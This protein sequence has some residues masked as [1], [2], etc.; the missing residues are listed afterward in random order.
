MIRCKQFKYIV[1]KKFLITAFIALTTVICVSATVANI[2]VAT[3]NPNATVEYNIPNITSG[4]MQLSHFEKIYYLMPSDIQ[5]KSLM[6]FNDIINK[7]KSEFVYCG[8]KVKHTENTWEFYYQGASV[9][10]RN[11]TDADLLKIFRTPSI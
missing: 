1:M 10:V 6:A 11:A 3:D 8:V 7:N 9:I 5:N 4:S 2:P